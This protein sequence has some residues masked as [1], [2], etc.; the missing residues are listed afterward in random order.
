VKKT[1]YYKSAAD[2]GVL[3][4]FFYLLFIITPDGSQTHRHISAIYSIQLGL[5]RN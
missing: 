2:S 1:H 3:F 5:C 4:I